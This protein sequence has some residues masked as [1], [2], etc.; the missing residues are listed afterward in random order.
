MPWKAWFPASTSLQPSMT[1]ETNHCQRL[2]RTPT[3]G[4]HQTMDGVVFLGTS[5]WYCRSPTQLA[6]S[7][8]EWYL[9]PS[10]N[11]RVGRID[12]L[13]S[14]LKHPDTKSK[15]R[16]GRLCPWEGKRPTAV[17]SDVPNSLQTQSFPPLLSCYPTYPSQ[18]HTSHDIGSVSL[19]CS[20]EELKE[21]CPV[22]LG[23]LRANAAPGTAQA[24]SVFAKEII[25]QT[26]YLKVRPPLNITFLDN[27]PAN[28]Q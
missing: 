25:C 28:C 7:Q 6:L 11:P 16:S 26:Y 20:L 12:E 10:C 17:P 5:T 19:L 14:L 3:L 9:C 27:S 18:W 2:D 13:I 15:Y 4:S 8:S 21:P 23:I 22:Y 24:Q 1:E